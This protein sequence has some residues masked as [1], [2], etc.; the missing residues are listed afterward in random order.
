MTISGLYRV[1][2]ARRPEG[3]DTG[4]GNMEANSGLKL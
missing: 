3:K 2:L 4:K 1:K